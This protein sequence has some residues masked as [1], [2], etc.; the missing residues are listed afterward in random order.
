MTRTPRTR[1][2]PVQYQAVVTK[3]GIR[4]RNRV[5]Y[6]PTK[7]KLHSI[8][9]IF[10]MIVRALLVLTILL[11]AICLFS[12][13]FVPYC[14]K[15]STDLFNRDW[16]LSRNVQLLDTTQKSPYINTAIS[17]IDNWNYFSHLA[18]I[19]SAETMNTHY[20]QI[21]SSFLTNLT[22]NCDPNDPIVVSTASNVICHLPQRTNT[23]QKPLIIKRAQ[24]SDKFV[25]LPDYLFQ[26]YNK[27]T[28]EYDINWFGSYKAEHIGRAGSKNYAYLLSERKAAETS[29]LTYNHKEIVPDWTSPL[30][31]SYI[32]VIY[33]YDYTI[34]AIVNGRIEFSDYNLVK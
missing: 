23:H 29:I 6:V 33:A 32:T 5:Q 1:R 11:G 2:P 12:Y 30:G 16:R 26:I 24:Y 25:I 17:Y 34:L 9:T 7:N 31:R 19:I 10:W 4:N 15:V 3:N 28:F 20:N 14:A 21:L 13:F 8:R 22:L 18:N 27:F